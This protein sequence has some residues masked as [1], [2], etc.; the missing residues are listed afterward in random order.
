MSQG[1]LD[2]P[3]NSGAYVLELIHN[4]K[5]EMDNRYWDGYRQAEYD[6]SIIIVR[7]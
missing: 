4:L 2:D 6:A 7:K 3:N 5:R 1:L